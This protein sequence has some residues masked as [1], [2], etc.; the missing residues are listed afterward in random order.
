MRRSMPQP[1]T[2]KTPTGGMK[3]VIMISRIVLIII[4]VLVQWL[5]E[6]RNLEG[7]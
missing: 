2:R 7:C 4:A 1:A 5:V 3:I 6:F